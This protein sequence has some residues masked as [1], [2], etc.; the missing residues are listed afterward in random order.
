MKRGG[1]TEEVQVKNGP[2][3][4]RDMRGRGGRYL[5][6]GLRLEGSRRSQRKRVEKIKAGQV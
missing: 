3:L 4:E 5:I 1:K 6:N 2:R